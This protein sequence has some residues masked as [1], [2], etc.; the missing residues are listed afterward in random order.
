[1]ADGFAVD[2]IQKLSLQDLTAEF[3]AVAKQVREMREDLPK[4][5]ARGE[6]LLREM[7]RRCDFSMFGFVSCHAPQLVEEPEPNVI[8]F[9]T[10]APAAHAVVMPS[11]DTAYIPKA[12]CAAPSFQ[13]LTPVDRAGH[14]PIRPHPSFIDLAFEEP[15]SPFTELPGASLCTTAGH[16]AEGEVEDSAPDAAPSA[17]PHD[18][19][20]NGATDA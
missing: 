15:A 12:A 10:E 6:A 1:M 11:G 19:Y 9:P 8:A 20:T 4:R 18:G 2:P 14:D 13:D 17:A 5:M 3:Q 7:D 16:G